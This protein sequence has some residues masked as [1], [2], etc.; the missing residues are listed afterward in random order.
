MDGRAHPWNFSPSRWRN[1]AA[2]RSAWWRRRGSLSISL[3]HL[4]AGSWLTAWTTTPTWRTASHTKGCV[5]YRRIKSLIWEGRV[6]FITA[7]KMY[8]TGLNRAMG[9]G[10]L[11]VNGG[12]VY[13]LIKDK[14]EG[15]IFTPLLPPVVTWTSW[16][17]SEFSEDHQWL[18]MIN[19]FPGWNPNI[20]AF[21]LQTT[22]TETKPSI[23]LRLLYFDKI[24]LTANLRMHY[25]HL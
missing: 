25:K 2:W 17:L 18:S 8:R 5:S 1:T 13:F 19:E 3:C 14:K 15:D 22:A 24:S 7:L 20:P 23:A 12:L 10:N 21:L 11:L 9:S 6:H 4:S 16:K